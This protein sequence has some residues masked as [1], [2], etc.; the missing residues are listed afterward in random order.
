[1]ATKRKA[2]A[3][4]RGKTT[5]AKSTKKTAAKPVAAPR[6]STLKPGATIEKTYKGEKHTV[7][8]TAEGYIHRGKT[9]ASLTA[10]AKQITGY[11]A[12]S[13]PAFFGLWTSKADAKGGAK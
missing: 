13:G 5:K 7:Q 2:A 6:P 9:Y 10:I 1:M 4:K 3:K 12:I 11:K 8:A